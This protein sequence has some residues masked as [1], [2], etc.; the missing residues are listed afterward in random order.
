MARRTDAVCRAFIGAAALLS[1]LGWRSPET[2]DG[3][4]EAPASSPAS[5]SPLDSATAWT[6]RHFL[7][8]WRIQ[9]HVSTL[10]CRLLDE[11]DATQATGRFAECLAK[12]EQIKR[13]RS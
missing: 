4:E 3:Q 8:Q 5:P 1:V 2:A 13:E 10:E 7:H 6:D 12:L 11:D 9:E